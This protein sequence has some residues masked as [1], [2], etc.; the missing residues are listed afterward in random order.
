M[1]YEIDRFDSII[2]Q[3]GFCFTIGGGTYMKDSV[4]VIYSFDVEGYFRSM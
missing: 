1:I 2:I 3:I 4:L